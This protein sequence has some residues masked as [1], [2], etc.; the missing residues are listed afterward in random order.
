MGR[1]L[2]TAD[3]ASA[4]DAAPVVLVADND[5]GVSGLLAEILESEGFRAAVVPDGVRALEYLRD[6]P[7]D[8]LVCD[9]D[10]PGMDGMEVIRNLERQPHTPPVLVISGYLDPRIRRAL[11]EIEF[12]RGV[13]EKPFD[14]F[15]FSSRARELTRPA[16][17]ASG[18]GGR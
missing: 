8:L 10:M 9:L 7:V 4:R 3:D 15:G 14:L 2:N 17:P 12:V 11:D 1:D 16:A 13:F 5:A 18:D 6:N